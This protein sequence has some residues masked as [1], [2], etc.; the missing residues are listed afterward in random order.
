MIAERAL[1]KQSFAPFS[2]ETLEAIRRKLE[3][4]LAAPNASNPNV[5]KVLE[6]LRERELIWK[7]NR[8]E[9]ALEDSAMADWLIAVKRVA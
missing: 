5:Q 6:V 9:Y 4:A 7:A 2:S 8:G 1:R 3:Q